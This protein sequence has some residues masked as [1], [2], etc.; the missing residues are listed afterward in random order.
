MKHTLPLLFAALAVAVPAEVHGQYFFFD[1]NGDQA[2]ASAG[3]CYAGDQVAI[4]VWLD[5]NHDEYGAE[6]TCATGEAL[7]FWS[8]ELVFVKSGSAFSTTTFGAW[9]NAIATFAE[10]GS[11][12]ESGDFLRVGYTGA[13]LPPGKY[14]LGT[15]IFTG[16]G[17]VSLGLGTFPDESHTTG[18]WSE[19]PGSRQD[20]FLRLY[21]DAGYCYSGCFCSDVRESTWGTIKS[22]YR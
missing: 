10:L 4:D 3:D 12:V 17:C 5:T 11:R 6:R 1:T 21:E 7:S 2:C 9:T 16:L 18:I 19:C 20:N 15:L 22:K 13:A 14:R 8:Y